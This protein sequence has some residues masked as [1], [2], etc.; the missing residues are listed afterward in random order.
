MTSNSLTENEEHDI[1]SQFLKT[2]FELHTSVDLLGPNM[3][4][5]QSI[6]IPN[7]S[8]QLTELIVLYHSTRVDMWVV[9]S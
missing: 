2:I 7:S 9:K 5:F 8:G 3:C 4:G 6:C 1:L